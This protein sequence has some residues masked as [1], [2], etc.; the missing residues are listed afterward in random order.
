MEQ[1]YNFGKKGTLLLPP[2]ITNHFEGT[3][4]LEKYFSPA[5]F[6]VSGKG[7]E[8]LIEDIIETIGTERIKYQNVA[9]DLE[10]FALRLK[11]NVKEYGVEKGLEKTSE[12]YQNLQSKTEEVG[13]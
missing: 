6:S 8:K 1:N 7:K 9:N 3:L 2:E 13:K 10:E 4:F 12:Y 5:E 11:E